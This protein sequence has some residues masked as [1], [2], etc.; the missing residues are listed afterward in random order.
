MEPQLCSRNT[1]AC[2]CVRR[3]SLGSFSSKSCQSNHGGCFAK[4]DI[5]L[6]EKPP[7]ED[8]DEDDVPLMQLLG[9][10]TTRLALEEPIDVSEYIDIDSCAPATE[11][12]LDDGTESESDTCD[13]ED[14]DGQQD[15]PS[16]RK[17]FADSLNGID[18]ILAFCCEKALSDTTEK[19]MTAQDSVA[20]VAA[21]CKLHSIFLLM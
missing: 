20:A 3:L 10:S 5:Y 8:D 2:E 4:C 12:L 21:A 15:S 16:T 6:V 7:I 18:S 17:T 19:L 11:D 13:D 9:L 14:D 1:E